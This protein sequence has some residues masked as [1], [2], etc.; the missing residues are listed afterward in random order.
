M[1][2][3]LSKL[4]FK[5]RFGLMIIFFVS[6]ISFLIV[7][8]LIGLNY[9]K[10]NGPIYKEIS[11]G[12][13]LI[14]DILPPP[15]YIIESYLY[16]LQI[17]GS[18]DMDER[19]KLINELN[20]LKSEYES[21]HNFWK[22]ALANGQI[23]DL[24]IVDSYKPASEFYKIL[25]S[26][27]VPA[28]LRN[29]VN[30]AT[31]LVYGAL[32][33]KYEEHRLVINEVVKLTKEQNELNENK[34]N[35]M[36]FDIYIVLCIVY[37]VM[38][39]F[40]LA[41]IYAY[42]ESFQPITQVTEILKDML[43][44]KAIFEKRVR[45]DTDDELGQLS[46]YFNRFID[47]ILK[48]VVETTQQL[49]QASDSL[50]LIGDEMS[51]L[52]ENVHDKLNVS[53]NTINYINN[54]I[55]NLGDSIKNSSG[56]MSIIASSVEE[57]YSSVRNLA[58]ASEEVSVNVDNVSNSVSSI[59]SSIMKVSETSKLVSNSVNSITSSVKEINLSVNG[60]S[61]NCER[62]IGIAQNANERVS[63]TSVIIADLKQ[64]SKE[65]EKIVSVINQ[66]ACVECCN[67]G[68]RSRRG[69]QRICCGCK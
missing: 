45:I 49:N 21:N 63:N 42:K 37:V 57:I 3:F 43:S 14:S 54:C 56:N 58:S 62:S 36:I 16:T 5:Q 20:K 41:F 51:K 46:K 8:S 39:M 10:V 68:C 47:E 22:V 67:R 9:L 28:V 35:K 53:G 7:F 69:R 17:I 44:G 29:D 50:I 60:I 19:Q 32:K 1:I 65:I 27:F 13:N 4:K 48:S 6:G 55:R 34:I 18:R 33:Q 15:S 40:V 2:R 38:L 59:S 23:R 30:M 31:N 24:M 12:K 66:Y 64:S 25:E 26:E 11:Q 61:R 52:N